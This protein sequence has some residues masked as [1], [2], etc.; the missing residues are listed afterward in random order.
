MTMD[1]FH[2]FNLA[3]CA[4]ERARLAIRENDFQRFDRE[5]ESWWCWMEYGTVSVQ[6]ALNKA[7]DAKH[8]GWLEGFSKAEAAWREGLKST[9][10]GSC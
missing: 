7:R 1:T 9:Y 4:M 10:A 2:R 5:M 8:T 3:A 6:S